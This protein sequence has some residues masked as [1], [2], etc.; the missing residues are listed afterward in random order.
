MKNCG[1]IMFWVLLISI[2]FTFI[3]CSPDNYK[4]PITNSI[5]E[6]EQAINEN[7]LRRF[8]SQVS[9]TDLNKHFK[10]Y[11]ILKLRFRIL[12]KFEQI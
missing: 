1:R 8:S 2:I 7:D 6:I 4:I 3:S 9:S 12:F 11:S 5:K 10:I